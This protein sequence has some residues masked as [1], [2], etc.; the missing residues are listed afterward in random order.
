MTITIEPYQSVGL[1]RF[2]MSQ[3]EVI[4][5]I[6]DPKQLTKNRTGN[7]VLWYEGLNATIE[8]GSLVEVGFGPEEAVS[9]LG[10]RP[11]SEPGGFTM[12]CELDGNPQEVLGF[13]VLEN[14]GITLTGFHDKD[15]SQKAITVFE[16]GRW[17][18]LKPNMKSFSTRG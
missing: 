17:D 10:V 12:L 7:P 6:G 1:L 9:V 2:G 13:I 4:A 18:A 11:F 14:L 15:D 5:A 8:N 3:G 16:R